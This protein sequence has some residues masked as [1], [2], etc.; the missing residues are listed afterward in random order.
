MGYEKDKI[1]GMTWR[2]VGLAEALDHAYGDRKIVPDL[3]TSWGDEQL[4]HF[5][6][7]TVVCV[8]VAHNGYCETC[9]SHDL[10]ISIGVPLA[11]KE[12]Q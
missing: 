5:D 10:E 3:S 11:M 7:G 6:D 8:E 2:D 9:E 12:G 1:K 4:T